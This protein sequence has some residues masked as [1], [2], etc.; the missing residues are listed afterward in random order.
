MNDMNSM[1]RS[2]F[3]E[4]KIGLQ[5]QSEQKQVSEESHVIWI[6]TL[7]TECNLRKTKQTTIFWNRKDGFN[8]KNWICGFTLVFFCFLERVFVFW[9]WTPKNQTKLME[10]H[11]FSL[12]TYYFTFLEELWFV[13]ECMRNFVKGDLHMLH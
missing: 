5:K 12:K 8:Q 2:T 13:R 6:I 1:I 3:R 11:V 7:I 9:F 4:S 10:K